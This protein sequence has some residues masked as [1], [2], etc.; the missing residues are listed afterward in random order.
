MISTLLTVYIYTTT[1]NIASLPLLG[2]V[3]DYNNSFFVFVFGF[4]V[5]FLV[6]NNLFISTYV[7]TGMDYLLHCLSS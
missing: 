5:C 6:I 1:I 2:G 4:F 3:M 7:I